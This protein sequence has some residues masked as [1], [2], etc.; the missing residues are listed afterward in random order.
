MLTRGGL[1]LLSAPAQELAAL[2]G[3]HFEISG[4]GWLALGLPASGAALGWI[5]SRL[6]VGRHLRVIEPK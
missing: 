6:A 2:Y 1:L 3:A 4:L 5:G